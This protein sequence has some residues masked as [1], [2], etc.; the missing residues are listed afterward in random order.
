M[1]IVMTDRPFVLVL[2]FFLVFLQCR[3]MV[4]FVGGIECLY[5]LLVDTLRIHFSQYHKHRCCNEIF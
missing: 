4:F 2:I 5:I 3:N 1:F